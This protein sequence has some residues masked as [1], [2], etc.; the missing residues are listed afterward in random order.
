MVSRAKK[1]GE[2]EPLSPPPVDKYDEN[3]TQLFSYGPNL[4]FGYKK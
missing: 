1:R 2:G 3:N 4:A